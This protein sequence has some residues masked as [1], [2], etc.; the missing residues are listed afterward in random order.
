M[1]AEVGRERV[2]QDEKWG[3]QNHPDGTGIVPEQKKLADNARAMCQ[4]AFAEGRGDWAHVLVEEVRE[5][6]AESDPAALRTELIQVA[7]VAVAWVEAIGRRTDAEA[8][9]QV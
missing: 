1:L 3:E 8:G 7:A 6:L 4:Q 5:A 2:R 9:E